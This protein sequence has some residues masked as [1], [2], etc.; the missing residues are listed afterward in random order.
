MLTVIVT[1]ENSD[2]PASGTVLL[3]LDASRDFGE[4]LAR[5]LGL[6]LGAHEER[7]FE[8]SEFKVRPLQ[9]VRRRRVFVCQSLHADSS[10]S[11]NDKLC[12]LLFLIGAL[13]DAGAAEVVAVVPYLAYARKDRRT[14]PRDP[15]TTRYVAALFEAVGTDA[16]VTM[17]VHNV[18]AFEN[19]FRCGKENLP[20]A[21][22]FVEHF[23]GLVGAG[24]RVVVLSPDAGGVK[25]AKAFATQL[26]ARRGAAVELAF[27]EKQR[28]GGV[29]SGEAFAG[30]VGG[31]AV[32][33]VDDLIAGG[34]TVAR[35][36]RACAVRGARAIHAAATHGVFAAGAAETLALPE[37]ESVVVTDTV[38]DV[39]ERC[40]K[41]GG[42]LVVLDATP[43]F[44]DAIRRL[45]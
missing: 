37:L 35:A 38:G 41:L 8:D 24:E 42:K 7:E 23:A 10:V 11:A 29:V 14:K 9:S 2:K 40:A 25:R 30:D 31:A 27:M 33:I 19:A 34:T 18:A 45:A 26:E 15:V 20:A 5:R 17:D 43:V 22:L 6:A 4:R 12:R 13:K 3:A 36:V 21:P 28:S 44:A 39:R 16:V 32:I 1:D